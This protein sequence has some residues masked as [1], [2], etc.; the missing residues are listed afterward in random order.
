MLS[1]FK[2]GRFISPF[3]LVHL[4]LEQCSSFQLRNL[5]VPHFQS[6]DFRQASSSNRD[7]TRGK[8]LGV[9]AS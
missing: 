4:E 7:Q 1:V 9:T 6:E 2:P 5:R 8:V 3:Q